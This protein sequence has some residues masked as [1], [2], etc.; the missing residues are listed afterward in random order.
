M[1]DESSHGAASRKRVAENVYQRRT[2][3]GDVVYEVVFR[4]VDGRQKMRKL[5]ATGE[6][7]AVR[8]ARAT[9]AGRDGGQR[10]V[11]APLTLDEIASRDY[12]PMLDS[13]VASGRRS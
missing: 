9:L 13:L 8:E 7:A 6:R 4:D 5:A 11:A 3:R 12:F 10:V 2:K 1:H